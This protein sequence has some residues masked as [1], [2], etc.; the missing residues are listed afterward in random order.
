MGSSLFASD[1]KRLTE[2]V[3]IELASPEYDAV[4]LFVWVAC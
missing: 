2:L 3:N 4:F 1:A